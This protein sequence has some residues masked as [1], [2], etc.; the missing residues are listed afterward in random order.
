MPRAAIASLH[1][2]LDGV[3]ADV[4][5]DPALTQV[6]GPRFSVYVVA[7]DDV[8]PFTLGRLPTDRR[9]LDRA[10][11]I[12][13]RLAELCSD[14]EERPMGVAGRALGIDPNALRY[15]SATGSVRI[16]WDG[17]RQPTVRVVDPPEVDPR[18]ARHELVRRHLHHLGPATPDATSRWAGVRGRQMIETFDELTGELLRVRTPIGD[19]WILADDEPSFTAPADTDTGTGVVRLLPSGDAYWLAWDEGRELL[20]G[21]AAHRDQ[22][23]TPRVW[24]GAVVVA[25]EIV[26]TWRRSQATA[27][28]SAWRPLTPG[29]RDAIEH[30]AA[31]LPLPD[32]STP[33]RV[34]WE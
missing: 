26:G 7:A 20:V 15:A 4:L 9:G 21:S 2:R 32:L 27:T 13:G 5:D 10:R 8:A 33:V 22:L 3:D 30:E 34:S 29:E 18:E 11:E 12:A 25:G 6:W 31:S 16:S 14:G 28:V 19:A 23:W 17:A 1:A 24:P